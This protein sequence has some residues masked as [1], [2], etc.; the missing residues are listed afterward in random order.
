MSVLSHVEWVITNVGYT[1]ADSPILHP[2]NVFPAFV[3]AKN[4]IVSS[5]VYVSGLLALFVPPSNTYVISYSI[6]VQLAVNSLSPVLHTSIWVTVLLFSSFHHA[7]SYPSLVGSSNV[8]VAVVTSYP[9]GFSQFTHPF[10]LYLILYWFFVHVAV[11]VLFPV[12]PFSMIFHSSHPANVYHSL[13]GFL[14][15][16]KSFTVYELG[17][18]VLSAHSTPL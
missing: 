12:L 7:K 4:S 1:V 18:I 3:G 10:R 14:S 11:N 16:T 2:K 13:L 15:T 8:I 9:P 5:T 17:F 6:A